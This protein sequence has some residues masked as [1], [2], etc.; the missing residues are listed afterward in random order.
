MFRKYENCFFDI[1]LLLLLLCAFVSFVF[2]FSARAFHSFFC[3]PLITTAMT[4]LSSKIINVHKK[5]MAKI[6]V[7]AVMAV[8]NLDRNDVNFDMIK[9]CMYNACCFACA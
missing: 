8:A 9:V 5:Q 6:A 1:L 4:T 2:F 3:Q 7:D